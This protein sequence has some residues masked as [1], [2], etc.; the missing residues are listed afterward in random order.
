MS[1]KPP[2]VM[3]SIALLPTVSSSPIEPPVQLKMLAT[4]KAPLPFSAPPLKLIPATSVELPTMTV[5][6]LMEAL[7]A[8]PG[9]PLGVQL[10]GLNQSVETVPFQVK[11]SAEDH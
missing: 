10:A 5:P 9:T 1:L 7:S 4:V 3:F 2:P 6:L 11:V 8:G